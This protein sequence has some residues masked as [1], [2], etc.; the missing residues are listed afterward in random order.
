MN[1]VQQWRGEWEP[2]SRRAW[3]QS[4][5]IPSMDLGVFYCA[6]LGMSMH[7]GVHVYARPGRVVNLSCFYRGLFSR[8]VAT[9]P[10]EANG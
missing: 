2:I 8:Y 7:S 4:K 3:E 6:D 1:T 9:R 10:L 5:A